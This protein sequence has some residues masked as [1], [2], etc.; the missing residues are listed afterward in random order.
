[1]NGDRAGAP[2]PRSR[3]TPLALASVVAWL[4][5]AA[6]TGPVGLWWAVGG[7]SVALGLIVVLL[8]RPEAAARLRP[9]ARLVLLGVGAGALMAAAT[10][11]L[12]PALARLVPLV[13]TDT[14]RLYGAFRGPSPVVAFAML[15][16]IVVGE[17]LVWRG[18]VQTSL[19]RCLGGWRGVASA[20]A[21][22]ALVQA[23][24]GSPV[25]VAV[26]LLCGLAWGALRASTASLVPALVAHLLWDV[27]VLLWLPLSARAAT[28]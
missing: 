5:A 13:A 11:L 28:G 6:S 23:P 8:D 10:L 16:P 24:L 1:M 21:V 14:A 17:E 4:I 20:A 25:L 3:S 22:Y 9:S 2:I 26:A 19:V 7:V 15:V 18:V 12:Y 27:V